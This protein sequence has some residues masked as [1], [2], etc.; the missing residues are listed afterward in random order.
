MNPKLKPLYIDA[1]QRGGGRRFQ[2]NN[3]PTNPC[4]HSPRSGGPTNQPIKQPLHT[5][6]VSGEPANQPTPACTARQ[7][8][9]RRTPGGQRLEAAQNWITHK[10]QH[11]GQQ[12]AQGGT[13]ISSS[14]DVS[15]VPSCSVTPRVSGAVLAA[16]QRSGHHR[17]HLSRTALETLQAA[18]DL[19]PARAQSLLP[20]VRHAIVL[21]AR[22]PQ[23]LLASSTRAADSAFRPEHHLQV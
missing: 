1:S 16:G 11:N 6:P 20:L 18:A 23:A 14:L 12:P 21:R 3:Q 4:I 22:P 8:E 7:R 19:R 17:L 2:P 15:F 9:Q 10:G 5:Q 13:L